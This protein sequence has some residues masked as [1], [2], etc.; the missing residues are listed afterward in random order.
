MDGGRKLIHL[1]K[2]LQRTE[3]ALRNSH[4][5]VNSL[6]QQRRDEMASVEEF[7]ANIR[8]LS[9]E[10]DALTQSLEMENKRLHSQI[11]QIAQERDAFIQENKLVAQLLLEEGLQQYPNLTPTQQV[12][13]LLQARTELK[14]RIKQLET[15]EGPALS[16][17]RGER[18]K[19]RAELEVNQAG[20]QEAIGEVR[21]LKARLISENRSH[22]LEK[23]K[24]RDE[25]ECKPHLASY[26]PA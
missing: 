21:E 20:M 14:S 25:L 1:W 17:V 23:K 18:D 15:G 19:Y 26:W 7:V 12:Q 9:V 22:E 2:K 16:E 11:Q 13:Q 10:K 6:K 3:E 24:L 8:N 5:E 4:L